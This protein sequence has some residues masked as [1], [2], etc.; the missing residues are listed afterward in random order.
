MVSLSGL[1][2]KKE[3]GLVRSFLQLAYYH[4]GICRTIYTVLYSMP[5]GLIRSATSW[6]LTGLGVLKGFSPSFA[7]PQNDPK[8]YRSR[9][10][11][12][13]YQMPHLHSYGDDVSFCHRTS[14]LQQPIEQ[15][16]NSQAASQVSI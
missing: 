16:F 6:L 8:A 10:Y 4:F 2:R 5:G 1:Q 12:G 9:I 13:A 11:C 14:K 15:L 7:L 3:L